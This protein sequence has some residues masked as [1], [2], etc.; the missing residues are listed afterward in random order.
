MDGIYWAFIIHHIKIYKMSKQSHLDTMFQ[1]FGECFKPSTTIMELA[2]I[3]LDKPL[4]NYG[5]GLRIRRLTKGDIVCVDMNVLMD[6]M[7]Q[8][9]HPLLPKYRITKCTG[10]IDSS[11]LKMEL[12]NIETNE[13]ITINIKP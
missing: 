3:W 7:L 4:R 2:A 9:F 11:I 10:N 1:S 12:E 5:E 6:Y 13:H 8:D